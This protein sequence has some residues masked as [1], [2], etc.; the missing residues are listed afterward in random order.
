MAVLVGGLAGGPLRR[1]V[2]VSNP[3]ANWPSSVEYLPSVFIFL[4]VVRD[5]FNSFRYRKV[6]F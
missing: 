5:D 2:P 6:R 3:V 1:A 4:C